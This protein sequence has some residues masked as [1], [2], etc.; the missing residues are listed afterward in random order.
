MGEKIK[1]ARLNGIRPL[2]IGKLLAYLGYDYSVPVAGRPEAVNVEALR[3]LTAPRKQQGP[4]TV[5][6][7]APDADTKSGE[8]KDEPKPDAAETKKAG[9]DEPK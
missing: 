9:D 1:E 4:S 6:T 3:R 5:K 2:L 8:M 7:A